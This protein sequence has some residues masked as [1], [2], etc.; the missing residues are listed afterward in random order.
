MLTISYRKCKRECTGKDN[1]SSDYR[2]KRGELH[3]DFVQ[4][5]DFHQSAIFPTI[6]I[7][8]YLQAVVAI[9][10]KYNVSRCLKAGMC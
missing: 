9:K 8:I 3:L 5:K 2:V 10:T 6:A 1:G 4:I 7:T